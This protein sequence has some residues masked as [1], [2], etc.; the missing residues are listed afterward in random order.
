MK[1]EK[2]KMDTITIEMLQEHI[3]LAGTELC[4]KKF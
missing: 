2:P 4:F 1:Y 3:A